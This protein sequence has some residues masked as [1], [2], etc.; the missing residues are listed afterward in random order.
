VEVV[1]LK[2]ELDVMGDRV[3][4]DRADPQADPEILHLLHLV[5]EI[6]GEHHLQVAEPLGVA[7]GEQEV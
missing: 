7:E 2:V 3:A 1:V 6:T 4:E 5:K